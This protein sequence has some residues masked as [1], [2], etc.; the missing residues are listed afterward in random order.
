MLDE[1]EWQVPVTILTKFFN[2]IHLF[3]AKKF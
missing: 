3:W 2:E 1:G